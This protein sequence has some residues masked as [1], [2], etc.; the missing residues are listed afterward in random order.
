MTQSMQQIWRVVGLIP[1]GKVASYGQVAD[2]AGLPGRARLTSK[3][4]RGAPKTLALPW[5]RV[6]RSNGCIAF[7]SGSK[8][9]KLQY[10]YLIDEGVFVKNMRISM[11]DYQWQPDMGT[12]L[13]ELDF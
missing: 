8:E 2:L 11:T 1:Y 12:I 9:A 6:L 5:H 3:A 4:L 13:F 7:P 10:D